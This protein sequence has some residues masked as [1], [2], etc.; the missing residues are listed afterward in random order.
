MDAMIDFFRYDYIAILSLV[1]L[2]SSLFLLVLIIKSLSRTSQSTDADED[3]EYEDEE[4]I[5]ARE[6]SDDDTPLLETYLRSISDDLTEIKQRL[7]SVENKNTGQI[8]TEEL[9]NSLKGKIEAQVKEIAGASG[10]PADPAKLN[11]DLQEIKLRL[12]AIHKII[13]N[14]GEQ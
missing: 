13:S 10:G 11:K 2:V 1:V 3:E 12:S 6:T 9:L 14:L 7:T 8:P 4:E 5:P